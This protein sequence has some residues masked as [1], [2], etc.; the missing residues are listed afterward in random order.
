MIQCFT[1]LHTST[2]WTASNSDVSSLRCGRI[3]CG[4]KEGEKSLKIVVGNLAV[5]EYHNIFSW[6]AFSAF[7][8]HPRPLAPNKV[9][10]DMYSRITPCCCLFLWKDF[11]FLCQRWS[12]SCSSITS[13][14]CFHFLSDLPPV[15]FNFCQ[16]CLY[17]WFQ[18]CCFLYWS[19]CLLDSLLW[20]MSFFLM[21]LVK[22]GF[23]GK[24][25]CE[26]PRA[27]SWCKINPFMFFFT[28]TELL[29]LW[30]SCIQHP[31]H[32]IFQSLLPTCC[33][34]YTYSYISD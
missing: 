22:G 4:I 10:N 8:I 29:P 1:W 20:E 12:C 19:Y 31:F 34:C 27:E 18:H 21:F 5:N 25:L 17:L 23:C 32:N 28:P 13:I 26:S 15:N 14:L 2:V 24:L 6:N 7:R 16:T 11:P 9:D 3:Q 33:T 30:I